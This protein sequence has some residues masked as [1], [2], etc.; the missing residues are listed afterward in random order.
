[1]NKSALG[2]RLSA[3]GI[4]GKK[5]KLGKRYGLKA[6]VKTDEPEDVGEPTPYDDM[7]A[8]EIESMLLDQQI[9]DL[10]LENAL[11]R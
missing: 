10:R 3:L 6:K 5:E 8:E 4:S 9:D 11:K 1:M 2:K 7:T